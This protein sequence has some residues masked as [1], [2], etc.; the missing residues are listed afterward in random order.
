LLTPL[1]EQAVAAALVRQR[2][3][4]AV[5]NSMPIADLNSRAKTVILAAR[6]ELRPAV[7]ERERLEALL[8]VRLGSG[9]FRASDRFEQSL[10]RAPDS[11]R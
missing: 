8:S 9:T 3:A 7:G 11:A 5:R 6:R 2:M 4:P 1:I 10:Q